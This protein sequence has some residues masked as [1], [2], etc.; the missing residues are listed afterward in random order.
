MRISVQTLVQIPVQETARLPVQETVQ[1]T[2]AQAENTGNLGL[3]P[4]VAAPES[5]Q[6]PAPQPAQTPEPVTAQS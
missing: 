1:Q 3:V 5:A 2:G 4:A 6:Q